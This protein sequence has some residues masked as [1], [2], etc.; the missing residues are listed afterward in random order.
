MKTTFY[1]YLHNQFKYTQ[2]THLESRIGIIC[3]WLDVYAIIHGSLLLQVYS[4]SC[5]TRI[6]IFTDRQHILVQIFL[7]CANTVNRL[8]VHVRPLGRPST[9]RE[10]DFTLLQAAKAFN[11]FAI[12]KH[13]ACKVDYGTEW[14]GRHDFVNITKCNLCIMVATGSS[15]L[16]YCLYF[17][18]SI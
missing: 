6:C 11:V 1:K 10:I 18:E 15:R 8:K 7:P 12:Y 9:E 5:Y 4:P 14:L 17:S 3:L 2:F 16:S 13:T